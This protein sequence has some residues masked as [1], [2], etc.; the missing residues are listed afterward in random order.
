MMIFNSQVAIAAGLVL[1]C[2]GWVVIYIL[3]SFPVGFCFYAIGIVLLII[4][5]V[6]F[7]IPDIGDILGRS[8]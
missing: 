7:F 2:K 6:T 5:I 8:S 4:G 3:A 1:I